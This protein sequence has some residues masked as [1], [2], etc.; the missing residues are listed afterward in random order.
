MADLLDEWLYFG[1]LFFDPTVTA[2][3]LQ[4]GLVPQLI[5]YFKLFLLL[6]LQQLT[7]LIAGK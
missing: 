7:G 6:W 5:S 1:G 2:D 4:M 3:M